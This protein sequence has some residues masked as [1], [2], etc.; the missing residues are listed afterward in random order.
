MLLSIFS[1]QLFLMD[2]NNPIV[3]AHQNLSSQ[4]LPVFPLPVMRSQVVM[5]AACP[6]YATAV[7]EGQ[8]PTYS[9]QAREDATPLSGYPGT[10]RPYLGVMACPLAPA[11]LLF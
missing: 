11:S 2:V 5:N 6:S 3:W 9:F 7:P 4:R 1:E 10:L 8:L